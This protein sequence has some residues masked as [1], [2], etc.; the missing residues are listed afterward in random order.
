MDP[1]K[2][3]VVFGSKEKK[4]DGIEIYNLEPAARDAV[5]RHDIVLKDNDKI[6]ELV[7]D[8]D[9]GTTWMCDATTLH[10]IYPE[11]HPKVGDLKRG[12]SLREEFVLPTSISSGSSEHRFIGKIALKIIKIFAK[13][14]FDEG[15]VGLSKR[16]ENKHLL[17]KISNNG[18]ITDNLSTN[19]YLEK[20]AGLFTVNRKFEFRWFDDPKEHQSYFLFIHGTN[21]NTHTAFEALQATPTWSTIHEKYDK[22]LA[23]QHRTLTESPLENV[24][25]LA[26]ILP[27][28]TE[29]HLLTHSRG[30]IVGD[31]I[32]KY[33]SSEG[34]PIGFTQDQI[35]LLDREGGREEDIKHIKQLNKLFADKKIRIARFIR[36]AC[37]AAGTVLVSKRLDNMLNVMLNLVGGIFGDIL[38]ELL[39]YA[40]DN[41]NRAEVL[42]GL[43]AQN[44]DSP[45]MEMLNDLS[46]ECAIEGSPLA[47]I[48]GNANVGFSGKGLLAL[49]SKLFF[50]KRND[51]VVNT[52]SM[53]LGVKRKN[54]I[55]YFFDEGYQVSHFKFFENR[56]TAEAID[57]ALKTKKGEAISGY[58]SVLQYAVPESDRALVEYGELFPEKEPPSGDKPIIILLPGIMGSN[59][60]RK[61]K[62]IWLHYG[63]ILFGGLEE[64]RYTPSDG[65][66]A[67]SVVKTSYNKLYKWLSAKYDVVVYPFD[68]RKPITEMAEE[69]NKKIKDLL[70]IGQP[71][72][73]IGHSMGGVLVRDF[74]LGHPQTWQQLNSSKGFRLIFL[75]SPLGGSHR[76]LAVLFGKDDII[77]KLNKLDRVNSKKTLLR[78][79]SKFSGILG[80]L[81][82]TTD[83]ENDYADI[84]TWEKMREAFGKEDWPL[85][86]ANELNRFRKY[87][88]NILDKRDHLDY[89]NMV[90]IAGKDKNTPSGYYLDVT[91][92]EKEL[93]FLHTSEGD[94]SVTWELGIPQQLVDSDAVYYTRVSHG[95]LANEP[96]LFAGIEEILATGG[97]TRLLKNKP[98]IRGEEKLFIAEPDFDFDL[99]EAGLKRSVLALGEV[100]SQYIRSQVPL[101]VSISNGDLR[102]TSYPILAGHFLND[103]ILYAEWAI[104]KYL[105]GSLADKNYLG[106]YPG[107]IGTSTIFQNKENNDFTGAIILGLGEP[108]KLNS[109][110][111]AETV[112]KGV[113]NY[114]LKQKSKKASRKELGISSLIMACGWG[115]LSME[116]SIKSIIEGVN[117]ANEKINSI[118]DKDYAIIKKLEFVELYQNRAIQ[119]SYI[120]NRI[121]RD[122][123]EN[124]NI[125]LERDG[126]KK[127]LGIKKKI[128]FNIKDDWWNRISVRYNE[129]NEKEGELSKMVFGTSTRESREEINDNYSNTSLIDLFISDA[130]KNNRWTP[131]SAKTL[132]E[133]MIPNDLKETLKK[134]G[135]VSWIVDAKAASYPW[136]L[137]Q[138]DI[139]IA[140]PLC[141]NAGMIRQLSISDYRRNIKRAS[142]S[143]A[144]V[145]ADPELDGFIGQLP[146]AREEGSKVEAA[147]KS[148]RYPVH[149]LINRSTSEI[150]SQLFSE[151]YSII[152]LAGHGEFNPS[153]PKKSGMVIGNG[154]FLSVFEIQKMTVVPD[155]V[156]VNCCHLGLSSPNDEKYYRERFKLAA[157]F[158]IELIRIG[159]KAVIAAGWAVNDSDALDFATE[160]YNNMFNGDQFGDAVWKARQTVYRKQSGSNT[161][162]AYQCYGDP[163]F[164]L[165]K[166]ASGAWEPKYIVPQEAEID[167]D[168]LL[169]KLEMGG[170]V[171][172]NVIN[173]TN[174]FK[175]IEAAVKENHEKLE[176]APVLERI[177]RI[178]QE[179]GIY[180]EAILKYEELLIKESASFSF[181]CME[182]YCNILP[183]LYV[184]RVFQ[185]AKPAPKLAETGYG[186]TNAVIKNLKVIL[187]VGRTSERYNLLGSAYKRLSIL[188]SNKVERLDAYKKSYAH[189]ELA[190]KG[191]NNN[192]EVYSLINAIEM[193]QFL[194]LNGIEPNSSFYVDKKKYTVRKSDKIREILKRLGE[195]I[196]SKITKN[197]EDLKYWDMVESINID[198]C[199]L[200]LVDALEIENKWGK[201]E[202]KYNKIWQKAGS[203]GKKLA[204]LEHLQFLIHGLKLTRGKSVKFEFDIYDLDATEVNLAECLKS[205]KAALNEIRKSKS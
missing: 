89:S 205:L 154:Q 176:T 96:D 110:Q 196:D 157:N 192:N 198:L 116:S 188:A 55:Q 204:E 143:R 82:L 50:L 179:L 62:E 178:Y 136:E 10:E 88:D 30:G 22:V 53:Y 41:K 135:N 186:K 152:H 56:N 35:E 100:T 28:N 185:R 184:K 24:V 27:N 201:I 191:G 17:H 83:E 60:S 33:C 119:A 168:N 124:F 46:D 23:F 74:I 80:L 47:L 77:R 177:S 128:S 114:L 131:K 13:K 120:L 25:K 57:L 94:Q 122:E 162:G 71:V 15:V 66:Q 107:E 44:P 113:L 64:L 29:L 159:V 3:L 173:V 117:R 171:E 199:L 190:R 95:A 132:F 165:D 87:R 126:I 39:M 163:F 174:S 147:L 75:G 125:N 45:F 121:L 140:K 51:L 181:S 20:G 193:E 170:S 11:L 65:I 197:E 112:E 142:E 129:G 69:F 127:L 118:S 85:P 160:F 70:K 138:D 52:D 150:V 73:I 1:I 34:N 155:L 38:K 6:I 153:S 151:E 202:N 111:L 101:S 195:E 182:K 92:P 99:S 108:E 5:N 58:K 61:K 149:S 19:H 156:F 32:N 7:L 130:S 79:F 2:K 81:P 161:W 144:L 86:P 200:F 9:D 91:G 141:I 189:Y 8:D 194:V 169:S 109:F 133:L 172:V 40:V 167:L 43:E 164:S 139:K 102:Y 59:L 68:W 14:K 26:K 203:P 48:T 134:K 148:A 72:K 97:T 180:E 106:L 67:N 103:G 183:K 21:S 12:E 115:G 18:Q 104:N 54:E 63:N 187:E 123:N 42:P 93:Y 16:L 98:R 175:K 145:V 166:A 105:N 37:P 31:I 146:G 84:T 36:V 76:I 158:G 137:L 90:Y 4:S 78:M 49:L